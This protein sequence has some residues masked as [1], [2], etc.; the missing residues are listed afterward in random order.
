MN[1]AKL[2]P[3]VNPV[4]RRLDALV[5]EW[6]MLA[7]MGGQPTGRARAVFEPLE[8]GAFLIGHVDAVPSDIEVPPEW[9]ANSPF[10]ITSI[11]GLDLASET[12]FYLYADGRGVYRVYRMSLN[13]GEWKIWG[14]SGPDFFQRF[15]G[16]FSQDSNTI[17]GR[18][19]ASRDGTHW[20]TDFDVTYS[21]AES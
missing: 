20:Q 5:G 21:K 12:F 13:D 6:D 3:T 15:S 16:T 4:L 2:K 7:S 19:E 9:L 1:A 18:W 17:T 14:Q 11:I 10:P 8:E